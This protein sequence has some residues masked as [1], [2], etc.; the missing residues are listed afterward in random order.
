MPT[1]TLQH[2][3][4]HRNQELRPNDYELPR[5]FFEPITVFFTAGR[6]KTGIL[7]VCGP[8]YRQVFGCF[9]KL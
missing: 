9:T 6:L 7:L 4:N 3:W 5:V 2:T 1:N 8:T